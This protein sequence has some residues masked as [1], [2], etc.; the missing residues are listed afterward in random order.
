MGAKMMTSLH[1]MTRMG[2]RQNK[3]LGL[4]HKQTQELGELLREFESL[5]TALPGHTTTYQQGVPTLF[6]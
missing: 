4:S 3:E 1:G 6:V 2:D 5:F